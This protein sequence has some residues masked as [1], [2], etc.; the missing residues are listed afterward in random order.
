MYTVLNHANSTLRGVRW[1]LE[2]AIGKRKALMFIAV[3]GS[4]PSTRFKGGK[5]LTVMMSLNV[6]P[7]T[8]ATS[9]HY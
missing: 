7:A 4:V 3:Y 8:W 5:K 1:H 6:G 2:C 9:T